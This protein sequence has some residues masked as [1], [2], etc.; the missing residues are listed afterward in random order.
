LNAY[1]FARSLEAGEV[2]RLEVPAVLEEIASHF[3]TKYDIQ[4]LLITRGEHGMFLG[5]RP[6]GNAVTTHFYSVPSFAKEV[7]DVTGAGDTAIAAFTLCLASGATHIQAAVIS[8]ATSA[9][10]V[11]KLGTTSI[12]L[13]ELRS[14]MLWDKE[15]KGKK[16]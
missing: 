14:S 16:E 4:A 1:A 8:N 13:N 7:Y 2:A 3:I 15:K 9:L 6:W 10:A 12:T 11:G 5:A